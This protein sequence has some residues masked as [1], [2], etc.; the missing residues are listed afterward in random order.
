MNEEHTN[1]Y[2]AL[3]IFL[4]LA[5]LFAFLMVALQPI[6]TSQDARR[7]RMR[8]LLE[9]QRRERKNRPTETAAA[10]ELAVCA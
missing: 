2:K 1:Y 6:F 5:L 3:L 7:D 10:C 4:I 9:Q 8:R